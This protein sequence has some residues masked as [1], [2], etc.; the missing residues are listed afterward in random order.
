METTRVSEGNYLAGWK[1]THET[2]VEGCFACKLRT[3]AIAPSTM[4]SRNPRAAQVK[5]TEQ[6]WEDDMPAYRRLR[7]NGIQPRGID[8]CAELE[9]KAADRFEVETGHVFKTREERQK[10]R[11]GMAQAAELG[12]VP[13]EKGDVK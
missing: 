13:Q 12:I 10:V 8:G 5:A 9:A 7:A 1:H 11:E 2:F 4:P 3:V 6:R